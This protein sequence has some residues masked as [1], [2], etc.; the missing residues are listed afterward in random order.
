M[1]VMHQ[2]GWVHRD[3]SV[4]NILIDATGGA[5]L[6]DLEYAKTMESDYPKEEVVVRF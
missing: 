2:S 4:G 6:V 3:L 5:R 1:K